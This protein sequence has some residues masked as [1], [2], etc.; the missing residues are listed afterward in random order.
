MHISIRTEGKEIIIRVEDNG[1]GIPARHINL[2]FDMFYRANDKVKGSGLG[3]YILKR[4]VERLKGTIA[5]TSKP[6]VGSVFTVRLPLQCEEKL[7]HAIPSA[8]KSI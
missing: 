8:H 2:I 5:V 6:A 4:A 1:Q 3:L 7:S